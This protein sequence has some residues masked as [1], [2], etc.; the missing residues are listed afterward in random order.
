[1]Y[2]REL[3][4]VRCYVAGNNVPHVHMNLRSAVMLQAQSARLQLGTPFFL[5]SVVV[6][7]FD[8]VGVLGAM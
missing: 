6:K 4:S 5:W 8:P 2:C 1:M 7:M 3:C